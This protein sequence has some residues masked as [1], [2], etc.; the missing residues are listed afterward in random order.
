MLDNDMPVTTKWPIRRYRGDDWELTD[1]S[2]VTEYPLTLYVN[3]REFATIVCTPADLEPMTIGFLASEGAIRSVNDIERLSIDTASGRAFADLKRK[4]ALD[5]ALFTKR[6]IASCCGKSRQSFYFQA[7]AQTAKPLPPPGE[8]P[9]ML[10]ATQ[11]FALMQRLHAAADVHRE[12]GGVH[13]AALADADGRELIAAFADIGRHNA[14]DKLY[15]YILTACIDTSDKTIVFS[16]RL[17][18]EVVLKA[19]KIGAPVLLSKSAPTD[20]ALQL[21]D[22]LGLTAVGFVRGAGMN[23]YTHA[24]RIAD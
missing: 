1:D 6:R 15:G 10:S 2:I 4:S 19:V 12:T 13:Q 5:P 16:G 22:E 3:D 20:L 21:A 9:P 23:V 11:C 18:S 14:L 24:G 17:A 7:D 8:E